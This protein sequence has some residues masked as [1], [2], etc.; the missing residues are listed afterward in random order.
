VT[1]LLIKAFEK[2]STLPE[3]IQDALAVE[4]LEEIEWEREW[5]KTINSP[6]EEL[7]KLAKKAL[8]E[9]KQGKTK[10]LGFDDL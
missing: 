6:K 9:F 4:L 7:N 2:A 1:T 8:Q 3:S 10:E 5:D